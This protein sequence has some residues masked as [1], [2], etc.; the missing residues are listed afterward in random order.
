MSSEQVEKGDQPNQPKNVLFCCVFL[1]FSTPTEDLATTTGK[2]KCLTEQKNVRPQEDLR[3]PTE[4]K[5]IM[6]RTR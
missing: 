5:E 2:M 3:S 6:N 4:K 1:F